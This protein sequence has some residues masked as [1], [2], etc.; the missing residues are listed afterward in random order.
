MQDALFSVVATI[1]TGTSAVM[2]R[3][4]YQPYGTSKRLNS[5]FGTPLTK[6][7]EW[8]YRF[9]G[10][11]LDYASG[12]YY[13]RATYLHAEL[14]RFVSRDTSQDGEANQYLYARSADNLAK[15]H[16]ITKCEIAA[17]CWLAGSSGTPGI[18]L[19][20]HCGYT[21][22]LNGRAV[23]IDGGPLNNGCVGFT[24]VDPSDAFGWAESVKKAFPLEA[25]WCLLKYVQLAI[26]N[27]ANG[28]I[29]YNA[30]CTNSNW[31]MKCA[32]DAC[33]RWIG[34]DWSSWKGGPPKGW[35]CTKC[36]KYGVVMEY[37]KEPFGG[38]CPTLRRRCVV[39]VPYPCPS[40]PF[41][42]QPLPRPWFPPEDFWGAKTRVGQ[43]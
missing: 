22:Y 40:L 5:T 39:S 33:S 8:E 24:M 43:E 34:M 41:Y 4:V 42:P 29:D 2:E 19:H 3:F 6:D 35:N 23:Y 36:V 10:R 7:L 26:N 25:C 17:H 15:E 20:N 31:Y 32:T 9:T 16:A 18:T 13:Y 30:Y 27:G 21:L 12:L 37:H 11:E 1:G 14:G 38:W 28:C